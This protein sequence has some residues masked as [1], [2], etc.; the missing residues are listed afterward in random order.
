MLENEEYLLVFSSGA[1]L[2]TPNLQASFGLWDEMKKYN[3]FSSF[4]TLPSQIYSFNYVHFGNGGASL[5]RHCCEIIC[6]N[7]G[8]RHYE[9]YSKGILLLRRS[10]KYVE[11]TSSLLIYWNT[12]WLILLWQGIARILQFFHC[13][14]PSGCWSVLYH[15]LSSFWNSMLSSS[16]SS[17]SIHCILS[18]NLQPFQKRRFL[19]IT[20]FNRL[21]LSYN[22]QYTLINF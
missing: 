13:I 6:T 3:F 21:A 18:T 20:K 16:K 5:W 12:F 2:K 14:N 4:N 11:I 9:M 10:I 17:F 19:Y 15:L 1:Q 8:W 22:C 7:I